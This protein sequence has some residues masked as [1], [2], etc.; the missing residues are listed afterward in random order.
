MQVRATEEY[1]QAMTEEEKLGALMFS[2]HATA[3]RIKGT[4]Y[5]IVAGDF[6]LK[7]TPTSIPA[8][9]VI[10][11][12]ETLITHFRTSMESTTMTTP[13]NTGVSGAK[14]I[15]LLIKFLVLLSYLDAKQY[16]TVPYAPAVQSPSQE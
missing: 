6:T 2:L 15:E 16:P 10:V 11:R 5:E 1:L 7:G 13:N 8:D 12:G 14:L 3:Y 4:Q 9:F